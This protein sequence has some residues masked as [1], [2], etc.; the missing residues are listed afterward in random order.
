M[1]PHLGILSSRRHHYHIPVSAWLRLPCRRPRPSPAQYDCP[2]SSCRAPPHLGL[3]KGLSV[4][5]THTHFARDSWVCKE[6]NTWKRTNNSGLI[7]W[8]PAGELRTHVA[9]CVYVDVGLRGTII[10]ILTQLNYLEFSV[11]LWLVIQIDHKNVLHFRKKLLWR[12]M[13][14]GYV[15]N[16]K[17][18][19]DM[20]KRD[21]GN[22]L[23]MQ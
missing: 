21:G 18:M 14:F 5:L 20:F 10:T 8:L 1:T 6:N 19:L 9:G 16:T 3:V 2:R 23:T 11:W 7:R 4:S 15:R 13:T 17:T 22:G 12:I